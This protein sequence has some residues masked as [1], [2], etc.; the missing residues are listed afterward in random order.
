[1]PGDRAAYL[2]Y[3]AGAEAA[4]HLPVPV[5]RP[6]ARFAS[7]GMSVASPTRRRQVERNLRRVTDDGLTPDALRDATAG[8]FANY[9]RYWYELFRLRPEDRAALQHSLV[10]EGTEH[11]DAAR[12]AGRGVI[13]AL[14]HLGNWD[15]AGAW[16]SG[17]VGSV[18]VVAEP[19]EPP[20]L[21]AWFVETR[22]RLGLEVIPLGPDAGRAVLR[23]LAAGGI[24]CLVA[25]RDITGDGIEV[26]FFGERTRLPAGPALLAF[27]SGAALV[28][29][30][31]Y[32]RG[33]DGH[34]VRFEPP[35][36]LTRAGRLRADVQ[37]VTQ[38]LAC[39]FEELIRRAPEQWLLMQ[40]NWPS[41]EA[42]GG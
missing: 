8:V 31:A 30:A 24:V 40:P 1:V 29:A 25:D 10:V 2:A 26:E 23:A 4:R 22:R 32:F 13:L 6:L 15:A 28:P 19:A 34:A 5:G 35:I 9:A 7:R 16:L 14:P 12:S 17:R 39:R 41:D 21:F 37:R 38:E 33:D 11:L 36:A 18:T 42:V 3:R 27:R 20:E